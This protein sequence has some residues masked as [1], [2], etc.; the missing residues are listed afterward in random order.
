MVIRIQASQGSNMDQ[1]PTLLLLAFLLAHLVKLYTLV[2]AQ[3]SGTTV[4]ST[5]THW[6]VTIG[7]VDG[8]Q[9]LSRLV[10]SYW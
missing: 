8:L 10:C 5:T 3:G 9:W 4:L 7:L 1:G 6:T 2:L